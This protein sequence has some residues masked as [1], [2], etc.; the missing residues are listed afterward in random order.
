MLDAIKE[1]QELVEIAYEVILTVDAIGGHVIHVP[2]SGLRGRRNV[3]H[4]EPNVC[5]R[6]ESALG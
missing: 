1:L 4:W 2:L 3:S 5:G 6:S